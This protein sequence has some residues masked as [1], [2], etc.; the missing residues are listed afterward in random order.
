MGAIDIFFKDVDDGPW[1]HIATAFPKCQIEVKDGM[2]YLDGHPLADPRYYPW[3]HTFMF[4]SA[5]A[6]RLLP[7][8]DHREERQTE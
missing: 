3:R 7:T 2:V 5:N 1:I 4:Q 6:G 8:S